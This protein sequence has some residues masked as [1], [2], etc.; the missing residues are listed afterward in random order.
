MSAEQD[1]SILVVDDDQAIR[2]MITTSLTRH[3]YRVVSAGDGM[4]A[5][6]IFTARAGEI[7]LVLTDL[8]MPNLD[9]ASLARILTW[10]H[11]NL[12]LLV[13][14][15]LAESKSAGSEIGAVQKLAL[16]LLL[17]PFTEKVLLKSIHELLTKVPKLQ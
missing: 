10:Q 7:A 16:A 3:N 6:G 4:E 9:G 14:S 11:P 2:E 1:A 15:G 17:K 5:I 12:R 8:D 13:M